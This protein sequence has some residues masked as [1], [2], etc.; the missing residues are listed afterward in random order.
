M[1]YQSFKNFKIGTGQ[2][3]LVLSME[4]TDSVLADE[5]FPVQPELAGR[6][7]SRPANSMEHSPSSIEIFAQQLNNSL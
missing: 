5:M 1:E 4:R 2:T 3:L 6:R 7:K